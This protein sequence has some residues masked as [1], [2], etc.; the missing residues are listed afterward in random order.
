MLY[1][2]HV[3]MCFITS[4]IQKTGTWEYIFIN[5][6]YLLLSLSMWPSSRDETL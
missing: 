3:L 5:Y 1:D 6:I 4:L 2:R